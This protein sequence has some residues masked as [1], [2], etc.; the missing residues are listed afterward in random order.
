MDKEIWKDIAGYEGLYQINNYG[1]VKS[2]NYGNTKK[3][4]ILKPHNNDGYYDVTLY[5]HGK[6]KQYKIHRLVA[7][8]FIP[9]PKNKPQVNHKDGNKINNN[10][11]NLEWVTNSEN[12]KHAFK[13]NLHKKYYGSDHNNAKKIKQYT[14]EGKFIK[15]WGSIV[16]ASIYYKTT[17]ENIFS[18]LKHKSKTAKGYKWEYFK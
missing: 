16:E 7:Q 2:L 15:E 18:C 5:K 3:E 8:N 6:H 4:K 9:N 17:K 1:D 10:V 11:N 12:I 13:T 14:L